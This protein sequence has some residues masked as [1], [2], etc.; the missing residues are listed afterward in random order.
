[1]W[2][3]GLLSLSQAKSVFVAL[4]PDVLWGGLGTP[5]GDHSSQGQMSASLVVSPA[6]IRGH[7]PSVTLL[8]LTQFMPTEGFV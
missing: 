3:C 5:G 7:V 8:G 4:Q 2:G 6:Q 1:M